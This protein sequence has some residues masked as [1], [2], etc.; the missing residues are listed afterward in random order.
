L[1]QRCKRE[2]VWKKDVDAFIVLTAFARSKFLAGG[3]PPNRVYVKPNFVE[4]AFDGA[5]SIPL[6]HGAVF[7]GRLSNEKGLP[8][9]LSAWR[10]IDYPLSIVGDGPLQKLLGHTSPK[11]VKFLGFANKEEVFDALKKSYMLIFPSE[12]YEGLPLTLIE[13]MAFGRPAIASG[14]GGRLEIIDDGQ[15]GLLFEPGNPDDLKRKVQM[16]IANNDLAAQMG[17]AARQKYLNKYTPEVNYQILMQVYQEALEN[18]T[19]SK[20]CKQLKQ[21]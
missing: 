21:G 13:A 14:M 16:L 3:L 17:R 10:D 7:I 1:Y 12:C 6:G 9:L 2:E 18:S 4:I 20:Q 19:A 15:T 8:T 11:N 5:Q